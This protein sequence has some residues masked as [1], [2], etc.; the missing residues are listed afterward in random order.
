M[1]SDLSDNFDAYYVKAKKIKAMLK[2]ETISAL[3]GCD[4]LLLP[5]TFSEAFEIGAKI[6]DPVAMYAEDMFSIFANLSG[7]P[8]LSVPFA[9][10]ENGLPLGLQIIGKHFDEAH[11]LGIANYIEKN[12]HEEA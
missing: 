10:G 1:A 5:A 11:I 7:V 8:A 4:A 6:N 12:Y 9:K 3:E 2:Q